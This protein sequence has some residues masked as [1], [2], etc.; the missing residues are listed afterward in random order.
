MAETT[1]KLASIRGRFH[2]TGRGSFLVGV[3]VAFL[4]LSMVPLTVFAFSN[5]QAA[6]VVL[7]EA[8]FTHRVAATTATGMN[9]PTGVVAD[10]S[11]NVWVADRN[12]NRVLEFL[13]GAGFTNGKAASVVLGQPDFTHSNALTTSNGMNG[14]S[15][16]AVD[17]SGN[18]W[19]AD[20][21]NNRVLEFLK[22]AG[23]TTGQSASIV[24]G[25]STF[26]TN[27]AATTSTG[28]WQ[29]LS[30]GFDP[31]GN[32][33]VADYQNYRVLEFLKG[34]G[35][36]NGQA[37]SVVLGEADFT[38]R[39]AATTATGMSLPQSVAADSSGNVWVADT[40]NNRVTLFVK[41]AGFTNGKAASVVLG[42]PDFTHSDALTTSNGMRFPVGVAVDSSGNVWVSDFGNNRVTLFLKGTGFTTSQ[43]A[44][45]VLGQKSFTTGGA[46]TTSTG[47]WTPTRIAFDPSGN[48][49]VADYQNYRVTEFITTTTTAVFCIPTIVNSGSATKCTVSV[50]DTAGAATTPTG[51]IKFTSSLPG[52]FSSASCKLSGSGFSAFCSVTFTP[53]STG[54]YTITAKYAGDVRHHGSKG[55][56]LL[57]VQ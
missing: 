27:A 53:S 35:F 2:P 24:L 50:S 41:G 39:V 47:M 14:P 19:V 23:F 45:A 30:L 7:G 20:T 38:H 40:S 11:G 4:I 16:V 57:N 31:S 18:I 54:V 49:W 17:S 37:A 22:G 56:F 13:K 25:Q 8:D 36:T 33:W 51:S 46:A 44:S 1:A 5:G 42:Q 34:A 9:L 15:G 29:P 48:L 32:L 21:G 28:L 12:N 52:T 10:S 26:T 3:A 55:T 43:A 6:S